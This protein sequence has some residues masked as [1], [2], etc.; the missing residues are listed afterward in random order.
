MVINKVTKIRTT[1]KI[2]T[3]LQE[4][5]KF[6]HVEFARTFTKVN[7]YLDKVTNEMYDLYLANL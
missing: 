3:N 2:F 4:D 1:L 6:K 7:H 5:G